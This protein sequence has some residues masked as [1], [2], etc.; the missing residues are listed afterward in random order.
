LHG[1][2]PVTVLLEVPFPPSVNSYYRSIRRGRIC[3]SIL[4][5]KGREYALSVL[6]KIGPQKPLQGRLAVSV[7]LFPPD[8]R[9]R[10]LDNYMKSLLDA[11]TKIGVWED[12][13]QIDRL[14]IARGPLQNKCLVTIEVLYE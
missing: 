3:Q 7:E 9:K 5:E 14:T 1:T 11:L 2:Y 4:S 12:D 10:D 8:R 6:E 13:S